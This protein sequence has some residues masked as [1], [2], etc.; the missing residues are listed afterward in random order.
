MVVEFRRDVAASATP[1]GIAADGGSPTL[2]C[3]ACGSTGR[4]SDREAAMATGDLDGIR[5]DVKC[6]DC[7]GAAEHRADVTT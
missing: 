7:A 3:E 1:E 6:G 4:V 2:T 5:R